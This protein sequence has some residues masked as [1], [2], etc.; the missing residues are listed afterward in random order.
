MQ[1]TVIGVRKID[2]DNKEG[3]HISGYRLYVLYSDNRVVGDACMEV[4][5]SSRISYNPTVG[6]HV[7]LLYN[8]YGS[9]ADVQL[10]AG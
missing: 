4:F 7:F 6:D 8:R 10:I 1:C 3:K 5:I 2:Y 9:V